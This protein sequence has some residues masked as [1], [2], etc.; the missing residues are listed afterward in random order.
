VDLAGDDRYESS[1][2]SFGSGLWNGIGIFR[3]DGGRDVI[4][5]HSTASCGFTQG[6]AA[7]RSVV[8][9][10]LARGQVTFRENTPGASAVESG[11]VSVRGVGR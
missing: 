10:F 9:V 8:G 7:M 4:V 11:S 3:D 1:G 6:V 5:N 2:T